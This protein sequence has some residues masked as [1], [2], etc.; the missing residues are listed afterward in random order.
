MRNHVL[1]IS[2][3]AEPSG[4]SRIGLPAMRDLRLGWRGRE[5]VYLR[6]FIR[7][8]FLITMRVGEGSYRVK[9]QRSEFLY[10]VE[11][12]SFGWACSCPDHLEALAECKHIQA[13]QFECGERRFVKRP[14]QA[15]CKFCDSPDIILKGS[16]GGRPRFKCRACGRFFAAN[17]GF[18][19]MRHGPEHV[20]IAVEVFFA[21]LSSRKT[22]TTLTNAGCPV[23]YKTIQNWG[24][25]FG[26]MMEQYLDLLRPH[27]GEAW[28]TD[29]LYLRIRGDRK[30]LFAMLDAPTRYWIAKQVATHKG[31][32][33]V[34]PMF[35]KAR[36]VAGKVPSLLTSDGASNFAEG[37]KR[38]Y[39]HKNY[40]WKDSRHESH[41]RMDGDI[42]NNQRESFNGNT[43]RLREKVTRGLKREDSAILSGLQVYHNHVRPHLALEGRTPGE[44]AGIHVEGGNPWLAIIESVSKFRARIEADPARLG[45]F[46]SRYAKR[47]SS[48]PRGTGVFAGV[49]RY[50][51]EW[52]T[53]VD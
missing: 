21:G 38:E 24:R 29:E 39:A 4:A 3:G 8:F 30:Y 18:E 45:G 22:A 50:G 37:H 52:K 53:G 16:R 2:A 25:R 32:D 40:L 31:T 41:I 36:E 51:V 20:T 26:G 49:R 11:R 23:T 15:L 48:I 43:L 12:F 27:L 5:I 33:D 17:L 10:E 28:R 46:C 35:R 44:A 47:R 34:R 42:N 19:G 9:S 14:D 1:G 7:V 13:V 6:G